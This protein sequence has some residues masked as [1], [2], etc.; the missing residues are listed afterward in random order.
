[1]TPTVENLLE[2]FEELS[3]SEKHDLAVAVMRRTIDFD[4]PAFSD[5]ELVI[6]A[7]ELF[8]ALDREEDAANQGLA[9]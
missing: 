1:M 5:D 6:A 3:D 8:L 4:V 7:E 2:I 9:E